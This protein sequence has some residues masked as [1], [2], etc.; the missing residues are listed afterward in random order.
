MRALWHEGQATHPNLHSMRS[1]PW[2]RGRCASAPD[3]TRTRLGYRPAPERCPFAPQAWPQPSLLR[4]RRHAGGGGGVRLSVQRRSTHL[5]DRALQGVVGRAA[6]VA[7]ALAEVREVAR[8]ASASAAS[9]LPHLSTGCTWRFAHRGDCLF[10]FSRCTESRRRMERRSLLMRALRA[11]R[12]DRSLVL[13]PKS[14]DYG[15]ARAGERRDMVGTICASLWAKR[16]MTSAPTSEI[17]P[18]DT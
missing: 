15:S 9:S 17:G 13:L 8:N 1:W 12:V 4:P 10:S 7:V 18:A 2:P 6:G 3:P 14:A 5:R 16:W 11:S